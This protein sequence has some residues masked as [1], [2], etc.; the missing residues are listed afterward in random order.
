MANASETIRSAL[1]RRYLTMLAPAAVILAGWAACR[2]AG[3]API[4][5]KTVLDVVGPGTFIAA[6]VMAAAAPLLCRVRFVKSVS[7][8][9]SVDLDAFLSF[10]KTMLS[11]A[12]LAT[13]AAA[14][15]YVA[16]VS[17]FHFGGAFLAALYAAYYYFPS[18][19]R[20]TQEMRLFRVTM[21]GDA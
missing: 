1:F 2:Q 20:V 19:K 4:L 18:H 13:Y 16:G 6:I 17:N 15:A 21:N 12:L 5:D 7:G 11:L 14:G 9:Q 8:Q 10:E 3:L